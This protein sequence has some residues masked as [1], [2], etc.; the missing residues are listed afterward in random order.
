MGLK[1]KRC[2]KG[3]GRVSLEG[4]IG[5]GEGEGKGVQYPPQRPLKPLSFYSPL[6]H[7]PSL[8]S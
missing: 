8:L 1:R 5:E 3:T 4:S 6:N 2:E 7:F